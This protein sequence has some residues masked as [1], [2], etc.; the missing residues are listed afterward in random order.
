MLFDLA[1][2]DGEVILP[3][4]SPALSA[5][6]QTQCSESLSAWALSWI[7]SSRWSAMLTPAS[8]GWPLE[9]HTAA[10][11]C[12]GVAMTTSPLRRRRRRSRAMKARLEGWWM[13]RMTMR[14]RRERARSVRTMSSAVVESRPEVTSSHSRM[15]GR[16]TMLMASEM[17]RRSPPLTRALV[18]VPV[19]SPTM[20]SATCE[21][22][23][24]SIA[25]VARSSFSWRSIFSGRVRRA[26]KVTHSSTDMVEGSRSDCWQ[27]ATSEGG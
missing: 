10:R 26:A 15:A 25:S 1:F 20:E 11:L 24:S 7:T 19:G 5:S 16:A 14:P 6:S 3:P 8:Q 21:R 2:L 23:S 9:A 17:R 4:P 22:P 13:V 18:P 12:T 27:Y